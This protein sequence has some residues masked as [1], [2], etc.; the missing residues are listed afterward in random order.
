MCARL[1][2]G[3]GRGMYILLFK[4]VEG[5]TGTFRH[6]R[7]AYAWRENVKKR[8]LASSAREPKLLRLEYRDGLH[9]IY[10]I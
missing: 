2:T 3:D 4:M 8:I 9:S 6:I 7:L 5:E 10:N 1:K